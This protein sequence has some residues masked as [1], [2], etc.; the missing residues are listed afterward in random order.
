M[1]RTAEKEKRMPK[2]EERRVKAWLPTTSNYTLLQRS[3]KK[4]KRKINFSCCN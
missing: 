2:R 4:K 3:N 1:P